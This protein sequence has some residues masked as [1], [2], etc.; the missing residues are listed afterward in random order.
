MLPHQQE[1]LEIIQVC[2]ILSMCGR[3]VSADK[4][5]NMTNKYIHHHQ[6]AR[7]IQ[8]ATRKITCRTMLGRYKEL[9]NIVQASSTQ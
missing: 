6:N 5:L 4:L 7:M 2:C 9:G 8:A 1:E 3:G